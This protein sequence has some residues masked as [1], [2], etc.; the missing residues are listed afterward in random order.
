MVV[1]SL[2]AG[3]LQ[4]PHLRIIDWMAIMIFAHTQSFA[5]IETGIAML[6]NIFFCGILGIGFAYLMPLI[7]SEKIYLKGWIYSLTVWFGIYVIATMYKVAGTLP[8]SV[9]TSIFNVIGSSIYGLH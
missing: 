1:W 2:V 9:E 3:A 6:A 5:V 7:K 8:T 4:V